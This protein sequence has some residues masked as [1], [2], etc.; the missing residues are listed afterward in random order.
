MKL[1]STAVIAALSLTV[2]AAAAPGTVAPRLLGQ[3]TWAGSAC[4]TILRGDKP[5]GT[6]SQTVTARTENGRRVWDVV[7]HQKVAA[8]GFDMRDHFVL[9]RNTLLPIRFDSAAGRDASARG[10]HRIELVY[11][12][13]RV[14]GT[15]E[16]AEGKTPIDVALAS[17]V[18]EG[19]LWGVTFAALPL[20]AGG[21]YSLPFWQ[22]D[23]G[24]GAFT[25]RVVGEEKVSTPTGTVDAWVLEAGADPAR[26]AR[27][28]IAKASRQELGYTTGPS[29][30]R[31]GGTCGEER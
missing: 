26:L 15:R 27:Y 12:N 7:V 21:T 25:V 22:Y 13:G 5:V 24:M 2:S 4:Y 6:T 14:R 10:Y 8:V 1:A 17:P 9:D 11:G 23:K 19:N 16:T 20:R 31:L 18:W 29:G 30:Q 28:Q 3:R